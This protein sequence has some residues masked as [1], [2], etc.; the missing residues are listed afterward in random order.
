MNG[1][2]YEK[3]AKADADVWRKPRIGRSGAV[4]LIILAVSLLVNALAAGMVLRPAMK[5]HEEMSRRHSQASLSLTAIEQA[6]PP[7]TVDPAEMEALLRRVPNKPDVELFVFALREIAD[8]SG[9]EIMQ[10]TG[11]GT[12]TAS[13]SRAAAA[14]GAGTNPAGAEGPPYS[15]IGYEIAIRGSF[16]Q[17]MNFLHE[18]LHMERLVSIPAW[19]IVQ[20]A[21]RADRQEQLLVMTLSLSLYAGNAGEEEETTEIQA[22]ETP[23][24]AQEDPLDPMM[25]D[26]QY[27][28]TLLR[29]SN[30]RNR[31]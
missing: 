21:P 22:V 1:I 7:E 6:P 27:M 28:E 17:L 11:R 19:S 12:G 26:R 23:P 25:G 15:E 3:K 5:R 8:R 20:E 2:A 18:V 24:P 4:L 31:N 16:R 30:E 13:G 10:L 29:L 14:S 9:V